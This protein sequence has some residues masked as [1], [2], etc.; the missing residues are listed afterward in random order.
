MPKSGTP[1]THALEKFSFVLGYVFY[2]YRLN[3]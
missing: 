2:I 3:F 1:G